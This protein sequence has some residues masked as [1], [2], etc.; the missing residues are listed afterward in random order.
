VEGKLILVI[1][2]DAFVRKTI[3]ALFEHAGARVITAANGAEGLRQFFN[4]RPDLV[5]LDIMMPEIDGWETCR[6]IRQ[7]ADTPII[8]LTSIEDE[9]SEVRALEM[10]AVDFVTKPYSS[11]VLLARARSALRRSAPE[12]EKPETVEYHDDHLII[13]LNGRRLAVN[14][15]PVALTKTEF[16]LLAYLV[17]N[18]GMVLSFDQ[19]LEAVWGVGYEGNTDYVHVYISRLRHKIERDARLPTYLV[20]VHGQGYLFEGRR[21]VLRRF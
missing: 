11:R 21:D 10:G 4:C 18:K 3:G 14:G 19:I 17:R 13:D 16:D 1:E 9:D 15:Q 7:L 12:T 6:Q 20:T 5:T 2:D 8:M